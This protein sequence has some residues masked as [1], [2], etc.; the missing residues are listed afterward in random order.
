[1]PELSEKGR[2][3]DV[4]G[5]TAACARDN[6]GQASTVNEMP[7]TTGLLALFPLQILGAALS[8]LP[9]PRLQHIIP[10]HLKTTLG[11]EGH[12]FRQLHR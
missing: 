4:N 3:S 11:G 1:M 6:S 7:Q 5:D 9:L 10:A 2:F 12:Q 8:Q